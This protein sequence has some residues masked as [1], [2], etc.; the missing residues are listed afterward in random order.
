[1]GD[2]QRHLKTHHDIDAIDSD[3]HGRVFVLDCM[4]L[5]RISWPSLMKN[6]TGN[7][8]KY[9]TFDEA[10]SKHEVLVAGYRGVNGPTHSVYSAGLLGIIESPSFV[11]HCLSV[12]FDIFS[13]TS[14]GPQSFMHSDRP[15]H[16]RSGAGASDK[17]TPSACL[18]FPRRID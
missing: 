3:A 12:R 2:I 18:I 10:R 6:S 1:M 11:V 9:V 4:K 17:M 5:M 15:D 16:W 13:D 8:S 14:A 7:M